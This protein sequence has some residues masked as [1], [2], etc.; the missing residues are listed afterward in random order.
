MNET[1]ENSSDF[2][3][4]PTVDFCFRELMKNPK[5]RA[6]FVAALLDLPPSGVV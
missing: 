1:K 3:M 6:G 2:I 5:V 4:L